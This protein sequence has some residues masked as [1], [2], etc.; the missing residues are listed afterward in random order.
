MGRVQVNRIYDAETLSSVLGVMLCTTRGSALHFRLARLVP[1]LRVIAPKCPRGRSRRQRVVHGLHLRENAD[2][3]SALEHL[4]VVTDASDSSLTPHILGSL[5]PPPAPYKEASSR[6]VRGRNRVKCKLARQSM[7][8]RRRQEEGGGGEPRGGS[9]PTG[10]KRPQNGGPA[11]FEKRSV[12]AARPKLPGA[13]RSFGGGGTQ[14]P[15]VFR[16]HV[17]HCWRRL[18][19]L[20]G[21]QNDTRKT[22]SRQLLTTLE[23]LGNVAATAC[24]GKRHS[25]QKLRPGPIFSD[26]RIVKS[27]PSAG[28]AGHCACCLCNVGCT[29]H[30]CT[31]VQAGGTASSHPRESVGS[32][33][34]DCRGR[35]RLVG[36]G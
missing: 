1:G 12:A 5:P 8:P 35:E 27:T 21:D 31:C 19:L 10:P 26:G 33:P 7:S 36:G 22:A 9:A 6:K 28:H 20:R 14:T 17:G 25:Q 3:A 11:T 23:D 18:L 4:R 30:R 24:K 32:T 29:S 16:G 13:T 2:N 34:R 15:A